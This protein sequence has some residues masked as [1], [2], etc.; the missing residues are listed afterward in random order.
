MSAAELLVPTVAFDERRP[1]P[2][3]LP[4][5][6]QVLEAIGG[7]AEVDEHVQPSHLHVLSLLPENLYEAARTNLAGTDDPL[8]LATA[9]AWRALLAVER[10]GNAIAVDQPAL[11]ALIA[12][13]V[14]AREKIL[15]AGYFALDGGAGAE[16][17]LSALGAAIEQLAEQAAFRTPAKRVNAEPHAPVVSIDAAG[18]QPRVRGKALRWGV[19]MTMITTLLVHLSGVITDGTATEWV[20]VGDVDRGHAFVASGGAEGDAASLKAFLSQLESKGIHAAQSPTGEW[21]LSRKVAQ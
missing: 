5:R 9:S 14:D 21:V 3:G 1:W 18:N 10:M 13:A 2:L 12:E 11:Q 19:A 4:T 15:A 20:V 8:A 17:L 7:Q 6:G 16:E